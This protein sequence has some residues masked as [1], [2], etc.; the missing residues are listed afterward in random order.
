MLNVIE[1]SYRCDTCGKYLENVFIKKGTGE[2]ECM[3]CDS[4]I[5]LKKR[6]LERIEEGDRRYSNVLINVYYE[7]LLEDIELFYSLLY[8]SEDSYY[9]LFMEG[10]TIKVN[11]IM[12]QG[13]P[14]EFIEYMRTIALMFR[15][16]ITDNIFDEL[17]LKWIRRYL[18]LRER[19]ID[20]DEIK[21][22]Y[23]ESS[24]EVNQMEIV[25]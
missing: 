3:D 1:G 6:K 20:E 17:S 24:I 18:E 16:T 5:P 7:Y 25:L 23:L 10:G 2:V 21:L 22:W 19:K 13:N 11:V 12:Y 15:D 9:S 14:K 8:D 4:P